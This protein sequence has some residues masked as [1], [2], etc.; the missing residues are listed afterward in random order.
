M[1]LCACRLLKRVTVLTFNLKVA[2]SVRD[3]AKTQRQAIRCTNLLKIKL[4]PSANDNSKAKKDH[5][6]T[7]AATT[8][9]PG[10]P[11]AHLTTLTSCL[12]PS[13]LRLVSRVAAESGWP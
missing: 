6:I 9:L 5:L 11:F 3:W 1:L 10:N 8:V 2:A 4:D 13:S 7:S 12:S